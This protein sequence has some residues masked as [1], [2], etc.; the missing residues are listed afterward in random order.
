LPE[1][2][3]LSLYDIGGSGPHDVYAVGAQDERIDDGMLVLHST[4]DGVWT[5]VPV[6]LAGFKAQLTGIWAVNAD[7]IYVAGH[8]YDGRGV[9]LHRH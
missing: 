9:I 4:G 1:A 5:P 8:S 3:V 7:D 2:N 6:P